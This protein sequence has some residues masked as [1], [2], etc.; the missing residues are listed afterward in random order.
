MS[1][2]QS[3]S[4]ID[5]IRRRPG[6]YVGDIRDGSGLT[7]MIWELF[8]NALD[9]HVGGSCR[10]IS[11]AIHEDGSVTVE[12]DGRGIPTH[13]LDGVPFVQ[14]ALTSLHKTPTLD[15]HAPH[16]HLGDRGVGLVAVNALS[17]WLDLEIVREGKRYRQRFEQGVACGTPEVVE[18][19]GRT[20]TTITFLPDPTI[21]SEPWLNA[22][23]IAARL[24]EIACLLPSLTLSFADHR[25]H[26]F[27]EP[28]GLRV[29]LERTRHPGE[30]VPAILSVDQLVDEIAVEATMEWRDNPWSSISSYANIQSTTEGGAHVR[31]LLSGL[32]LGLRDVEPSRAGKKPLEQLRRIVA[33]GLCAV[34]CV[35]LRDPTFESPTRSRLETPAVA[36]AVS[37]VVRHAFGLELRDNLDLRG[38]CVRLLDGGPG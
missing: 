2:S 38:R 15:G 25:K 37:K 8:A 31:G 17:S 23:T 36:T 11:I 22:G 6:M 28:R 7:H 9:E 30:R 14:R 5:I 13:D 3:E 21:F 12:D 32:A 33:R 19:S 1:D 4:D 16:E 34:V 26:E 29:F 27:H 10:A 35:R 20:G 24:R 18:S